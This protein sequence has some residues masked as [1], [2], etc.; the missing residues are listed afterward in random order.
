MVACTSPSLFAA[1]HVLHRLHAPRHP[2]CALSSLT[3]KFAQS[4]PSRFDTNCSQL[5]FYSLP[6]SISPGSFFSKSTYSV[7][8]ELFQ[9]RHPYLPKLQ[10]SSL[11]SERREL[12]FPRQ[13]DQPILKIK[14]RSC[15]ELLSI[16]SR[17]GLSTDDVEKVEVRGL[18]P[19]T[20]GLQ[21]PR[22]AKLSY[23]PT[24]Y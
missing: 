18:E 10:S 2:P 21:S 15:G 6:G 20:S 1:C 13:T 3:I 16:H 24:A 23:T 11:T 7:F 5:A 22:S 17:D 14:A 12:K 9:F 4:K 8:K 19:L